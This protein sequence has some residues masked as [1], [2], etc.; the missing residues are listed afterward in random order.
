MAVYLSGCYFSGFFYLAG[1]S[2]SQLGEVLP[3][4]VINSCLLGWNQSSW[5]MWDLEACEPVAK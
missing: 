3:D 2:S 5:L 1:V 4:E